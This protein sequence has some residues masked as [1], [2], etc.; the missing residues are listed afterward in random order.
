MLLPRTTY[1]AS[2]SKLTEE[3][4]KIILLAFSI[5]FAVVYG[6]W[7]S[8]LD[9]NPPVKYRSSCFEMYIVLNITL[10]HSE[11]EL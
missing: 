11:L 5:I 7:E 2:Q 3:V 10:N 1:L 4:I 9:E 8:F 6:L